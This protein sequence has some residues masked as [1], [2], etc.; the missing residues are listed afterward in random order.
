MGQFVS[1]VTRFWVLPVYAYEDAR[2][3]VNTPRRHPNVCVI[4]THKGEKD[5]ES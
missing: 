4:S 5:D 1:C 2:G 3:E